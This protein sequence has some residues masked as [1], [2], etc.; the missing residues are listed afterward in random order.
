MHWMCFLLCCFVKQ[1]TKSKCMFDRLNRFLCHGLVDKKKI[2]RPKNTRMGLPRVYFYYCIFNNFVF[3][4]L[5]C[6]QPIQQSSVFIIIIFFSFAFLPYMVGCVLF[7]TAISYHTLISYFHMSSFRC[8]STLY[9][10]ELLDVFIQ[11]CENA[12][13][14]NK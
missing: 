4:I 2:I 5:R 6:S 10:L 3:I 14:R 8:T 12:T 7:M 13:K 9:R 11:A 1:F